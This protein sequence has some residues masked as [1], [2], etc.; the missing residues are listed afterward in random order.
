MGTLI[1]M[2]Q[3]LLQAIDTGANLMV[4]WLWWVENRTKPKNKK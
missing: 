1:E 4:V 2:V 3:L